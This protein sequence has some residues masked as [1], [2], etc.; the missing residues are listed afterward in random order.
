MG[1]W[2]DGC[3]GGMG[4]WIGALVGGM[5]GWIGGLFVHTVSRCSQN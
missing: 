5:G 4:G 2:M 3:V 1:E